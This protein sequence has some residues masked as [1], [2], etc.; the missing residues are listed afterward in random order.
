MPTIEKWLNNATQDTQANREATMQNSLIY[1]ESDKREHAFPTS[2]HFN[3]SENSIAADSKGEEPLLRQDTYCTE[4]DH[5]NS[6]KSSKERN[7]DKLSQQSAQ[8]ANDTSGCWSIGTFSQ[9][10][11]EPVAHFG[12]FREK[13]LFSQIANPRDEVDDYEGSSYSSILGDLSPRHTDNDMGDNLPTDNSR[14]LD[15]H[16]SLKNVDENDV[17]NGIVE[18]DNNFYPVQNILSVFSVAEPS[19][20]APKAPVFVSSKAQTISLDSSNGKTK[21]EISKRKHNLAANEAKTK[22]KQIKLIE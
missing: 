15:Y 6:M 7:V 1:Q 11:T 19:V 10:E 8:E 9:E 20:T 22:T 4:A 18:F 5:Y 21:A 14:S 2:S 17:D 16:H 12:N 13:A 3:E